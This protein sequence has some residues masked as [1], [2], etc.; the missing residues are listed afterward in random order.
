MTPREERIEALRLAAVSLKA[1]CSTPT[2]FNEACLHLS[3]FLSLAAFCAEN[4]EVEWCEVEHL[5]PRLSV[6]PREAAGI[7][8]PLLNALFAAYLEIPELP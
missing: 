4:P 1:A 3:E 6:P 8:S 2:T 7:E 5:F